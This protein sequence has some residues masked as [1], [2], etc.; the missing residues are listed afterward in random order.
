MAKVKQRRSNIQPRRHPKFGAT[1]ATAERHS[2]A[3]DRKNIDFLMDYA[4]KLRNDL[5]NLTLDLKVRGV[6]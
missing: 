3:R 5:D 2:R 1:K 6:L 4:V